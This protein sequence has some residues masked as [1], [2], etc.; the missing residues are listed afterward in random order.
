MRCN[1]WIHNLALLAGVLGVATFANAEIVV[2]FEDVSLPSSTSAGDF[3]NGSDSAGGFVSQG[4]NFNND[5]NTSFGSW[6]GWSASNS[7]DTTTPGF[8]NQYSA[9]PGSGVDG[10][11]NFGVAF[12]ASFGG[13]VVTFPQPTQVTG[14]YLTNGT[15]AAQSMLNG[16]AFAKKF[17]GTTGNDPDWFLLEIIGK[18]ASGNTTGIVDFYLADYRFADNS[19]D[20]VVD[21]WNWVDLTSLG[22]QV[23]SLEFE[24]SSSDVG[25]FG[26]NTPSYFLADNLTFAVPEPTTCLLMVLGSLGVLAFRTPAS[27]QR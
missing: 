1:R 24:L 27:R 23:Q 16:D 17:G 9:F 5:Y 14:T 4:V 2:D 15:F 25:Q 7:T 18:D 12:D 21:T 6:T 13:A 20:F 3:Y 10:S 8:G 11:T 19:L 26:M 22:T